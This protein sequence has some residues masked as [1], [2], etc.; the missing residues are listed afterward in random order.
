MD[1]DD[2]SADLGPA[3]RRRRRGLGL[4]LQEL[5]DRSGV[6]RAMLSDVERGA[7]NPTIRVACQIAEALGCSVSDLLSGAPAAPEEGRISVVRG[8]ERRVLVDPVSGVERHLL[9]PGPGDGIEVVWYVV[10]AG[11]ETGTFPPHRSGTREHVVVVR[12]RIEGRIG[13][14]VVGLGP[15]DAAAFPADVPH[16]FRNPAAEPCEFLL[17]IDRGSP[18][19]GR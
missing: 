19:G 13:G 15:G 18:P 9:S 12:G 16:G 2:P 3:V 6:S 5:A 14:D 7:K 1:R 8:R 17:V 10:P 4:T 11:A